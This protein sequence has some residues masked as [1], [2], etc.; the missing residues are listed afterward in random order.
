MSAP[1]IGRFAPSPSGHL[2]FGSL[3]AALAS[4][5]DARAEGG[6]W[7]VRMEDIDPPREVAGAAS[8]ILRQLECHGLH[9]DG[10]V[11]YQSSRLD[12]YRDLVARLFA[13]GLA[14]RCDCSRQ[15]VQAMGGIYDGRCRARN[16]PATVPAA[17]RVRVPEGRVI[18]FNDLFQ[19]RQE[20]RLDSEVG[21]FVVLRKD[22]LFA[23]QLAVVADDLAQG[24]THVIRGMDLL[25]ST[26]RQVWLMAELGCGAPVY[27]HLPLAL[28]RH[29][30][31]L[32]KQNLAQDIDLLP[33]AA[34]LR[35]ALEWLGIAVP[36]GL[37]DIA[38]L[39]A[40]GVS[41][42][43]RDLLAGRQALAA[44]QAYCDT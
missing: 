36:P 31:K 24:I 37:E 35:L 29:Q 22:G 19:G 33:P 42:W 10:D 27:G 23:Y 14:Y 43:R 12:D 32:S 1:Y 18:A 41:R 40:H 9:W 25:D 5:L 17:V 26:A 39:L 38:A 20:Q 6:R 21:D 16:V 34:N 15:V 7:L 4:Y 3:I 8:H 2:H 13:K 44:P 30:Q 11:L 28:N